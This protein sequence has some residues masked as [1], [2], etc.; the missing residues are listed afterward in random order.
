MRTSAKY[1]SWDM[2]DGKGHCM[3]VIMEVH[4]KL[5]VKSALQLQ[6]EGSV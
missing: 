5:V 4:R 1:L 2:G 3:T 6:T